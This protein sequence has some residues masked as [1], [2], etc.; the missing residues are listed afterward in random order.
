MAMQER[1]NSELRL[2]L[3]QG[4]R[5]SRS[6]VWKMQRRFYLE[7]GVKAWSQGEIPQYVTTN[8]VMARA[9]AQLYLAWLRDLAAQKS[10]G[11]ALDPSQPIYIVELGAGSGRFA[12]HFLL[13]FFDMLDR[14]SL[15]GLRVIYVMADLVETTLEFWMAHGQLQPWRDAGRLDFASFDAES[16]KVLRLRSGTTLSAETVRNPMGVI[17][18]YFF[19]SLTQDAYRIVNGEL[20]ESLSGLS[21]RRHDVNHAD[22]TDPA[23]LPAIELDF[24]QG[25]PATHCYSD[26]ALNRLLDYYASVLPSSHL[27]FPCGPLACLASL[28][29]IARDRLFLMSADKGFHH[30]GDLAFGQLPELAHH[31]CIS[32]MVNYHAL[33]QYTTDEGGQ[34]LAT[35]HRH[36][37][38]DICGFLFGLGREN[39]SEIALA[40]EQFVELSSP[41][42][43]YVARN[44]L[45]KNPDELSLGKVLS[46][47]RGSCWDT[48]TYLELH[49]RLL[50]LVPRT[51]ELLKDEIRWAAGRVWDSYYHVGERADLGFALG[52]LYFNLGDY[53]QALERLRDSLRLHGEHAATLYNLAMC[54]QQL[55]QISEARST[56][57]KSLALDPRCEPARALLL[58]LASRPTP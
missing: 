7:H 13:H 50:E 27:L 18:N 9:Y 5:L 38:L 20:F 44:L 15:R 22:P 4:V 28:R 48:L 49:P 37:C 33:G 30:L 21:T 42:D 23:L 12:Y 51:P 55:G 2:I 10:E 8:P 41:D 29:S 24:S 53:A 52:L 11:A 19:D 16:D 14:S 40:Y 35:R 34:F 43:F 3:E 31:G 47:L 6:L 36:E 26:A 58:R 1:A 46:I 54:Y 32:M 57:R 25:Q 56:A 39:S 45:R 17:A